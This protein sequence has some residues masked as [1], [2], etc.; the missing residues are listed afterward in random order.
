ML[1]KNKWWA[2]VMLIIVLLLPLISVFFLQQGFKIRAAA[3]PSNKHIE[4]LSYK[5]PV[6]NFVSHRGDTISKQRMTGKVLVLDFIS[7]NCGNVND[8]K[9][10]SL[11]ELQEDYYGKT[12]LFRIIS[13]SISPQD[14]TRQMRLLSERYA[15]REIWH[16][17]NGSQAEVDSVFKACQPVLTNYSSNET[18]LLCPEYVYL[19]D[20]NGFIRG[21]YN[22]VIDEEFNA[23]YQDVLYLLNDLE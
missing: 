10:R 6:F 19:V 3:Q 4:N 14:S 9:G 20:A 22:P 8:G 12:K 2:I 11:F 21:F 13:V 18:N 7:Y 23:L 15:A 1:N 16:F 5:I 17:L